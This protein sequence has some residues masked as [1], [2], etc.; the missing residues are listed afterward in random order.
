[1]LARS[2]VWFYRHLHGRNI[3]E[4]GGLQVGQR[5]H[6]GRR[7][8]LH[9]K[10]ARMRRTTRRSWFCGASNFSERRLT[11][12]QQTPCRHSA[13][14]GRPIGFAV[15]VAV[16]DSLDRCAHAGRTCRIEII[17]RVHAEDGIRIR[18][19][20]RRPLIRDA[21]RRRCG[22][23]GSRSRR[24]C[25]I[26]GREQSIDDRSFC[27]EQR[28]YI[29][30]RNETGVARVEVIRRVVICAE[31]E[32]RLFVGRRCFLRRESRI[33]GRA[34]SVQMNDDEVV[35]FARRTTGT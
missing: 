23:R 5:A 1:M 15:C 25:G 12:V 20:R 30:C 4:A 28:E 33:A 11:C 14:A 10:T 31:C 26:V 8:A 27:V 6:A 32:R 18:R 17:D 22:F 2:D 9:S 34:S 7:A 19:H 21:D 16:I 13:P 29:I 3:G 35:R 24:A